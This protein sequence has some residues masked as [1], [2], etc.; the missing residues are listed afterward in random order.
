MNNYFRMLIGW[1]LSL[2]IIPIISVS[3][4][5]D[6]KLIDIY[7]SDPTAFTQGLEVYEN[8]VI[9]GTGRYGKSIIGILNLE[10][11]EIEVMGQLDKTYF[12]EGLTVSPQYIWQLTWQENTAF[13]RDK[14][15]F[16]IIDIIFYE[17]EGWGL[18][19]D[20][21]RDTLWMSD[22][23]TYLQQ[24]NPETFALIDRL[25]VRYQGQEIDD[26]NELEY[27]NGQIY[28]NIWYTNQVIAIN[29]ET[30][31]VSQVYDLTP[32][33]QEYF[34]AEERQKIDSL[35]GIAHIEGNRFYI[36]GKLYPL[37]FEIELLK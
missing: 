22:G 15:S 24:R 37:I 36:T 33:L 5:V 9:I 34:T 16:E 21:D 19:Y 20:S 27:A 25:E 12:G 18:A 14:N 17:G 11:G 2:T 23:T 4:Q 6:Y 35:N 26:I 32:I 30:G 8:Q 10:N 7:P 13:Q 1:L 29:P 31:E 28:A 3:S